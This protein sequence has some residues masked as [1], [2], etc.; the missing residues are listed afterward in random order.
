MDEDFPPLVDQIKETQPVDTFGF[1]KSQLPSD[2]RVETPTLPPGL[3]LPHARPSASLQSDS[4]SSSP[5][6]IVPLGLSHVGTPHKSFLSESSALSPELHPHTESTSARQ[7]DASQISYGSPVPKSATKSR[8]S[9]KN[10]PPIGSDEKGLSKADQSPVVGLG[11]HETGSVKSDRGL[12]GTFAPAPG[13][14]SSRPNTPLTTTSR[15]SDSSAPRQPRILRVVET[16]KLETTLPAT[17]SPLVTT[18]VGVKAQGRKQSLSS[19]SRPDTP[20]DFGS[21]GD[22]DPSTSVSRANSPPASS[23]IGSAPVRAIT[24]SQA[25]KERR[26]KA[27][28]AEA[29]KAEEAGPAEEPVQAPIIGR[30]RKTKKTPSSTAEPVD[31]APSSQAEAASPMKLQPEPPKQPEAKPEPVE[32]VK[33]EQPATP[34]IKPTVTEEQPSKPSP[35]PEAWRTNNT[36]EQLIKDAASGGR[37]IKDL[38]AER[39]QP[40]HLLLAEMHK[41][42]E[43]DLNQSSLFNPANISQRTDMQCGPDD[44]EALMQPTPLTAK[45]REALLRGE[46]V[47]VGSEKLK[48]RCLITPTGSVLRHL[49]PEEEERYLELEKRQNGLLDPRTIG[50]DSSNI[51]GGLKALFENP[52]K[53]KIWWTD[54]YPIDK[55]DNGVPAN[56][57]AAMQDDLARRRAGELAP[58]ETTEFFRTTTNALFSL[59]TAKA[60]QLPGSEGVPSVSGM[61][62]ITNVL[63][64]VAAMTN[65]ELKDLTSKSQKDL[66]SSR[67]DLD[68]MD[69][70]LGAML[71]RNKKIQQV[72]LACV[73]D[74]DK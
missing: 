14:A 22:F 64:E 43:L 53:Y 19:N 9:T 12:S 55:L 65:E 46:P 68:A 34:E 37:T 17:T 45:D 7:K 69:K 66:E 29:K 35:P 2:G 1:L 26:Q 8:I 38:L 28:E 47:R 31:V 10:L 62:E 39:S 50:D 30:K 67:K 11:H 70:K 52:E 58:N 74:S 40:L 42:R 54:Q 41:A 73:R 61:P 24:K 3:P 6:P 72:A 25:K 57:L 59:A 63:D 56:V 16:P 5:A 33:A 71:R 36:I 18:N 48:N 4:K 27:K 44:Y 20:G 13:S 51:N 23:R 32:N 49:M 15:L 60:N 21:E